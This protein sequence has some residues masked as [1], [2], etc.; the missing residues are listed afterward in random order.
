MGLLGNFRFEIWR[1]IFWGFSERAVLWCH[2]G[3]LRV[4]REFQ[5]GLSVI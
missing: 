3:F 2:K 4:A 1:K 5:K